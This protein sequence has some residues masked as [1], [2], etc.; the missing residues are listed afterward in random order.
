VG[1]R[2]GS[3][4]ELQV[5][6]VGMKG[7]RVLSEAIRNEAEHKQGGSVGLDTCT[8]VDNVIR[9]LVI[10]HDSQQLTH[11]FQQNNNHQW[12]NSRCS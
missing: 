1:R 10:Q 2:P 6:P 3:C 8:L 7:F 12:V 9:P 4:L 5:L 11:R